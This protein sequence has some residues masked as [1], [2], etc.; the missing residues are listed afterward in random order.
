MAVKIHKGCIELYETQLPL[1]P[2]ERDLL[3]SRRTMRKEIDYH[4]NFVPKKPVAAPAEQEVVQEII[5]E[6]V[7]V[8]DLSF[9]FESEE[10]AEAFDAIAGTIE[11]F[12]KVSDEEDEIKKM[13]VAELINRA[14]ETGFDYKKALRLYQRA[15]TLEN[16]DD[17]YTFLPVILTKLAFTCRELSDWHGAK[18]YY[19]AACEF[20]KSAGDTVKVNEMK[21]EIA[22]IYYE[23][24]KGDKAKSLLEE[25][26]RDAPDDLQSYLLLIDLSDSPGKYLEKA[27]QINSD[28]KNLLAEL[29]FKQALFLD[30]Q[31]STEEALQYYKKCIESGKHVAAAYTNIASIFEDVGEIGHA[32]KA[33]LE[34]LRADE[35][36]NN[37]DGAY[38]SAMKLGALYDDAKKAQYYK[39]ALD[40]ANALAEPL[41]I[42][43]ATTALDNLYVE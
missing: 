42:E 3:I 18:Q 13:G 36:D 40:Y 28:N 12:I 16:D 17:Y 26:I 6:P 39:K 2:L 37:K 10:S 31:G 11:D 27:L 15:L 9:I 41:Y 4:Q 43:A 33:L 19:N 1:K 25:I 23:T 22:R 5:E 30:E 34:S 7:K 32:I 14:K 21:R 29:Y 35:A 24:F 38:M 8:T 20:Y